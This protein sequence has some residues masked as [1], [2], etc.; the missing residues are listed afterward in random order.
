[1]HGFNQIISSPTRSEEYF[2][3]YEV[4]AHYGIP[5]KTVTHNI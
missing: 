5:D 4:Y 2:C 3:K 1:M